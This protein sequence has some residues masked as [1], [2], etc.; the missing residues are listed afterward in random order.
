MAGGEHVVK[1]EFDAAVMEA[2]GGLR[3]ALDGMPVLPTGE[4]LRK[5][6]IEGVTLTADNH[7]EAKR[8]A[9]Y[10][11]SWPLQVTYDTCAG[12]LT[13]WFL[14]DGESYMVNR[15]YVP[16]KYGVRKLPDGVLRYVGAAS[17]S[18]G[19]VWF[20]FECNRPEWENEPSG[21]DCQGP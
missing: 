3:Q 7:H 1:M 9:T 4:A 19:A 18:H 14:V 6:G 21:Q 16:V 5:F 13:V 15:W 10:E 12:S 20:V 17:D 8:V 11:R 2:I